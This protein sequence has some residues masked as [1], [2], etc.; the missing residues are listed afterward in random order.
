MPEYEVR[1]NNK[2][3]DFLDVNATLSTIYSPIVPSEKLGDNKI[4]YKRR[5]DKF[6][7]SKNDSGKTMI[8]G[9][10]SKSL[11]EK[12]NEHNITLN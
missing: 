9:I 10:I 5:N 8:N 1:K 11:R 12:L 6:Y 2:N 4:Q 7:V 3:M